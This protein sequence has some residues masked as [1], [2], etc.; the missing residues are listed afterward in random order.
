[1]PLQ[2]LIAPAARPMDV[3]EARQHVRQDLTDD[4]ASLRGL[5][6]AATTFAQTECHRTLI[7]TRYKLVLDSFPGHWQMGVPW[8]AGYSLPDQAILL[9]YGPV[10]A[11]RSITYLDM[12]GTRVTMPA[13]DYTADLSGDLARITPV[14]GKIWQPT[15]PQIGAVEVTFDA[16]DA[17]AITVSGN[18]LTIKGG[19]WRA[20]AVGDT[21]RLSNSGGAL[22][23]PL[24]PD[25]DYYVQST[26]TSASFTLAATPGGAAITLNSAGR[27][28]SYIGAVNEG[29]K[30]WMK[31]RLGTLYDLRADMVVLNR[32]RL[33]P[34]PYVDALLD[35]H[36]IELA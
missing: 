1:M 22:P 6:A 31:L 23:A 35:G 16:G 3:V 33:E 10:L 27:G 7:A 9:E 5:I 15:L 20:L 30:A 11:V 17:A 26:P 34:L 8:G 2:T 24:Q 28:T 32:G 36:R 14:F 18:V 21:V 13:S 25:T 12:S 4:D 19:V 29:I